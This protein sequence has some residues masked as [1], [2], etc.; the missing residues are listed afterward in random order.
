MYRLK[1]SLSKTAKACIAVALIVVIGLVYYFACYKPCNELIKKYDTKDLSQELIL[2][3]QKI[4]VSKNMKAE[5]KNNLKEGLG[6]VFPYNSI[7]S[8]VSALNRIFVSA[9]E[10]DMSFDPAIK[11]GNTVRRNVSISFTASNYDTAHTIIDSLYRCPYRCLVRNVSLEKDSGEGTW[12]GNVQVTF[13]E[14]MT[15]ATTEEGL[16]ESEE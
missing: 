5:I 3:Q 15:N 7:R 4:A 12:N 8:E 2:E 11:E 10:F 9:S 14:T 16:I 6:I 1:R 13:L